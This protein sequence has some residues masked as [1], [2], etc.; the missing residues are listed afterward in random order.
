[1]TTYE[2]L[3][4]S[5]TIISAIAAVAFVWAMM[6]TY[7]GQMNAQVF[8]DY[9]KRYDEILL[10]MPKDAWEAR[11]N[12]NAV[13]PAPSKE[14]SLSILRYLNLSSEEFYLYK[15]G[16]LRVDVWRIWEEEMIRTL[17]T[18]LLKRE[19]QTLLIEFVSYREFYEFVEEVQRNK[20]AK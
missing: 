9:N 13:L 19:W 18:P 17:Q 1:M 2:I 8:S 12:M 3:I 4:L 10:S 20:K 16:Y 14:L 5:A 7:K 15:R 11:F 6:S